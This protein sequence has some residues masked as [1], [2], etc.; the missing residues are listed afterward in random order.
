MDN[1]EKIFDFIKDHRLAVMSTVNSSALPEASA[2]GFSFKHV[3]DSFEIHIATYDSSRKYANLKRNPRVAL[4]VGWEHGKTAQI[5]GVAEEVTN[6][7]EIKEIEWADLEKMPTV[8]KYISPDQVVFFKIS[9]VWMR[10]SNF[11]VEPWER[12]EFKFV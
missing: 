3:G 4:V 9:P 10:Y 6:P 12:I 5:E 8:A 11:S 1:K 2:V 7:E